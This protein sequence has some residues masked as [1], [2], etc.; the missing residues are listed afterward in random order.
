MEFCCANALCRSCSLCELRG[1]FTCMMLFCFSSRRRHTICAL[2]TGVHT[3]ALPISAG[4]G[5]KAATSSHA[6]GNVISV[7][8]RVDALANP[9]VDRKG[10]ASG[11]S[12]SVR[13]D[14]GGRRIIKQKNNTTCYLYPT[15]HDT[16][17]QRMRS[18]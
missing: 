6:A 17:E 7:V 2:V 13:V 9:S 11:K 8:P 16:N 3:C 12:V 10:V 4:S 15:T 14:H 1:R 5:S 18:N